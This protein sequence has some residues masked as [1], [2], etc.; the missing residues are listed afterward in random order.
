MPHRYLYRRLRMALW[1]TERFIKYRVLHVDDTPHRIALGVALGFF[2]TWTPTI[3]V[4][5]VLILLLCTLFRANKLVGV[6]FA[7][8]SNPLTIIPVYYPSYWLGVHLLP[9]AQAASLVDWRAM[10]GRVFDGD[11]SYWDR[12]IGFWRFA[13]EIAAPMWVGSILIAL[14]IGGAA[15]WLTYTFVVQYRRRFGHQRPRVHL[16]PRRRRDH[17]RAM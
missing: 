9:G 13:L 5:I 14:L 7:W 17:R 11:L 4:Q 2:V 8:L 15:Y 3:G 16:V 1:Q 12:A 10:V 6:P